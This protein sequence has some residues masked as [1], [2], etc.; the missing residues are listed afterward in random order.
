MFVAFSTSVIAIFVPF[1][2]LFFLI[3]L[4]RTISNS[5]KRHIHHNWHPLKRARAQHRDR[6]SFA[7]ISMARDGEGNPPTKP[8]FAVNNFFLRKRKEKNVVLNRQLQRTKTGH[9]PT[10][11]GRAGDHSVCLSHQL[12]KERLWVIVREIK[13]KFWN[14]IFF[15]PHSCLY[16]VVRDLRL[17]Q[18]PCIVAVSVHKRCFPLNFGTYNSLKKVNK[19]ALGH[20]V[21]VPCGQ[22]THSLGGRFTKPSRSREIAS[23]GEKVGPRLCCDSWGSSVWNGWQNGKLTKCLGTKIISITL[24]KHLAF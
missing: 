16:W 5:A 8:T 23:L 3:F 13:R 19:E 12:D 20:F 14:T 21:S 10:Y 18:E 4:F 1:W 9:P 17:V 15:T 2:H 24:R 6:N 11:P 7:S 22:P